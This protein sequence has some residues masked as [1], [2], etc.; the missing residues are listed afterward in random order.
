MHIIYV[1]MGIGYTHKY[2]TLAY[3][4]TVEGKSKL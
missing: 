1:Y 4:P 3:Q 2:Q